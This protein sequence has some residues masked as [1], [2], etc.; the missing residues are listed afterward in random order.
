MS[1]DAMDQTRHFSTACPLFLSERLP[2]PEAL[3]EEWLRRTPDSG[4]EDLVMILH[5]WALNNRER[6]FY[7]LGKYFDQDR[8]QVEQAAALFRA[9]RAR[10]CL[11]ADLPPASYALLELFLLYDCLIHV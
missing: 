6:G 11:P 1:A 4:V 10:L 5:D 7:H 8:P 2:G 3:M 9:N